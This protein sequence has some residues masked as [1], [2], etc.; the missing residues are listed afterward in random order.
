[1]AKTNKV[2]TVRYY[3]NGVYEDEKFVVVLAPNK[4]EAY[5][6]AVY[7]RIPAEC[8]HLPYGAWVAAVT[9]QNGN[10]KTFDT[11]CGKPY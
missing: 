9:Y 2:Y 1:M 6:K 5:D 7:E 8:G 11:H 10:Y 3:D 4:E